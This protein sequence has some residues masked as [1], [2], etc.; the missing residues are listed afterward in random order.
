MLLCLTAILNSSVINWFIDLNAS[1]Y[2]RG[3][4][5]IGV[6]LLRRVPIP[7]FYQID[8]TVIRLVASAVNEILHAVD[9]VAFDKASVIDDV[10]LRKFYFLSDL[11]I[12]MMKPSVV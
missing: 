5:R 4:N 1:K 7:N 2:G 6:A 11:E 3:Y 10:V 9:D 8:R 12:R